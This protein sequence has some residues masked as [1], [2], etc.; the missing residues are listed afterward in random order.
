MPPVSVEESENVIK[1]TGPDFI[2]SFDRVYAVI[3]EWKSS[4]QDL[5]K[6]GPRLNFWRATTDNDRSWTNAKPWRDAGLDHLQHRTEEFCVERLATGVVRIHAK[7]RIAPPVAA[8]SFNCDYVYTIYGNGEVVMDVHGVPQGDWPDTLPRI[9][10]Q[11][12]LPSNLEKVSWFGRGPGESYIDSKQAGR[13]GLYTLD[14]DDLYTPYIR[15]QENGNR[16][17]VSWVTFTNGQGQGLLAVGTPKLDF[18][19]HRFTTEDLEKAG[20]TYDLKQRDEITLNLD[21]KH[22]GIGS[23]SCGPG[24]WEKYLLRPEEFQFSVRLRPFTR[25]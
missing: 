22:N 21:Y 2:L 24:P 15:P 23:A 4:G 13:F 7:T 25:Q 18:S 8:R 3:K 11:M 12:T 5:I 10:L 17:D 1:V 20:H 19:A 9:G 6:N 14:V 16:T